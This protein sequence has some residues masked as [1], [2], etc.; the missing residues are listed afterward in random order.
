L[1]SDFDNYTL[2]AELVTKLDGTST[3]IL[4]F[5]AYHD[6]ND[7]EIYAVVKVPSV[8][9]PSGVWISV[10]DYLRDQPDRLALVEDIVDNAFPPGVVNPFY[11]LFTRVTVFSKLPDQLRNKKTPAIVPGYDRNSEVSYQLVLIDD[12]NMETYDAKKSDITFDDNEIAAAT[13]TALVNC[14]SNG[15]SPKC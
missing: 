8:K 12:D 13:A 9:H 11:P 10:A 14:L 4:S 7:D 3:A 1:P 15:T 2:D 5:C 6:T